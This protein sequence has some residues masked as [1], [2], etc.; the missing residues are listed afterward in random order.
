MLKKYKIF[1]KRRNGEYIDL[2]FSE[3]HNCLSVINK[4]LEKHNFHSYYIRVIKKEEGIEWLD[5]GSHTE[6]F[7]LV[8]DK[9]VNKFLREKGIAKYQTMDV[10]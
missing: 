5:V 1:F 3:K 10:E 2:G 6:F 4:F 7:Y 8:I 9:K